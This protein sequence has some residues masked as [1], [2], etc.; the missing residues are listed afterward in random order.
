MSQQ[1]EI[2]TQRFHNYDTILYK[3][4]DKYCTPIILLLQNT[5]CYLQSNML[6]WYIIRLIYLINFHHFFQSD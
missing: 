5:L 4:D 3:L 2:W 1:N 6:S